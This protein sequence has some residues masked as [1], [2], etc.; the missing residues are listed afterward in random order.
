VA[1]SRGGGRGRGRR[2]RRR[3]KSSVAGVSTPPHELATTASQTMPERS[4]TTAMVETRTSWRITSAPSPG[5]A[6]S[7]ALMPS[8]PVTS[9]I[10][11]VPMVEGETDI[12]EKGWPQWPVGEDRRR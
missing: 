6:R 12:K 2:A 9:T 8:S 7:G 3:G 4:V 11:E 1:G 5:T 10:V